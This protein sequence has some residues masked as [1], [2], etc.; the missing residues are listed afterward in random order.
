MKKLM[1][2]IIV[3]HDYKQGLISPPIYPP[4]LG[5]RLKRILTICQRKT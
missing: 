2:K 4:I 1:D 3:C 5:D